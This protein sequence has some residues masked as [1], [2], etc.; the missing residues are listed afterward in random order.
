MH[1]QSLIAMVPILLEV[2]ASRLPASTNLA[3]VCAKP[4]IIV[5]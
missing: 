2:Y 1:I 5:Y 3:A 4:A